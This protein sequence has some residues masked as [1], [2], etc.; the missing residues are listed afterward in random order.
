MKHFL[1]R[2]YSAHY[3]ESLCM[4]FQITA[5]FF[6]L[7]C[8]ASVYGMKMSPV[9]FLLSDRV[10]DSMTSALHS[11]DQLSLEEQERSR[12]RQRW[13]QLASYTV[14]LAW[15]KASP[16]FMLD[17]LDLLTYEVVSQQGCFEEPKAQRLYELAVFLQTDNTLVRMHEKNYPIWSLLRDC[18]QKVDKLQGG[19]ITPIDCRFIR[20]MCKADLVGVEHDGAHCIGGSGICN[21]CKNAAQTLVQENVITSCCAE[22]MSLAEFSVESKEESALCINCGW[23]LKNFLYLKTK[24]LILAVHECQVMPVKQSEKDLLK[25]AINYKSIVKKSQNRKV[26][27]AFVARCDLV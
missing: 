21:K 16:D 2:V 19:S 7:V 8:T 14:S 27:M 3:Y 24:N 10:K 13:W 12:A 4:F 20:L 25:W 22:F 5:L 17:V 15:R 18:K 1:N 9:H 26:I 6:S 23:R 11:D